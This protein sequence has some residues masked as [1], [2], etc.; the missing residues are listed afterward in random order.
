MQYVFIT[1]I[2]IMYSSVA[3]SPVLSKQLQDFWL[4]PKVQ[5]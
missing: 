1:E 3:E 2:I 5:T 4:N